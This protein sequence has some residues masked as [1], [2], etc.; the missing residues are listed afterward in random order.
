MV[1]AMTKA[2]ALTFR[3][4]TSKAL[5]RAKLTIAYVLQERDLFRTHGSTAAL[6]SRFRHESVNRSVLFLGICWWRRPISVRR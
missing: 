1:M 4:I 6:A 5:E 3:H 2:T